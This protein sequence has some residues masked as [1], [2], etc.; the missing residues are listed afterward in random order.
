MRFL[1]GST[2]AVEIDA[3]GNSDRIAVTGTV[4]IDNNVKLVVTPLASHSAYSLGTQYPILTAMGG[5]AGTFPA[6]TRNSLIWL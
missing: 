4:T 6:W 3:S 5:I 2:Y 1:S